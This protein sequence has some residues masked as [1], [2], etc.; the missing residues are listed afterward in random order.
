MSPPRARALAAS[1]F[2][3]MSIDSKTAPMSYEARLWP[4]AWIGRYNTYTPRLLFCHSDIYQI[5]KTGPGFI[6]FCARGTRMHRLFRSGMWF[7]GPSINPLQAL[8]RPV[9]VP[10]LL[11]S[12]GL[13]QTGPI[14][15]IWPINPSPNVDQ[16]SRGR[17]PI[18]GQAAKWPVRRG[19]HTFTLP[20][21]A[22][23]LT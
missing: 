13:P 23:T 1:V 14:A 16:L 3:T 2:P 21:G 17:T 7:E 12:I 19:P 9:F 20:R 6:P 11:Q 22:Q 4:W 15:F 10:P 5:Q 18:I 8:G